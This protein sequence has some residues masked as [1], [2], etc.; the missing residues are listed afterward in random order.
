MLLVV[1]VISLWRAALA[2]QYERHLEAVTEFGLAMCSVL[3]APRGPARSCSLNGSSGVKLK[4]CLIFSSL[5]FES[6]SL[7]ARAVTKNICI[8]Q[9]L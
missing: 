6:H 7:K 3:L 1:K 4:M 2:A 5:S 8:F 9:K